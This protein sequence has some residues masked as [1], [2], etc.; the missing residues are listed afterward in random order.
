MLWREDNRRIYALGSNHRWS[1][2]DDTWSEGQP[3]YSCGS[4][5]TPPTPKRGFGKVWCEHESVRQAVG[6][7]VSDEHGAYGT[8]QD[9]VN[10]AIMRTGDGRTYVLLGDGTWQE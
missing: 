7:A 2:Y 10:G 8:V 4:H 3:E 5:S 6:Q 9:F 1:G